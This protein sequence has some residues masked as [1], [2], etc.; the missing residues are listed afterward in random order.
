MPFVSRPGSLERGPDLSGV[1]E[2]R[3]AQWLAARQGDCLGG[4]VMSEITQLAVLMYRPRWAGFAVSGRVNSYEAIRRGPA[5]R[6]SGILWL[7][8]DGRYRAD[9]VDEDDNRTLHI[10]DGSSAWF[11]ENGEAYQLAATDAITPFAALLSPAWVLA[12]YRLEVAGKREYAGRVAIAITGH[13]R[14]TAVP[15]SD[16]A[17]A[18]F[19]ALVDAE[20]GILLRYDKLVHGVRAESAEFT[21]LE[22][23][24]GDS[25]DPGLFSRPDGVRVTAGGTARSPGTPD[26]LAPREDAGAGEPVS[27][28]VVSQLYLAGLR[29]R[30]FS[31]L[32]R[33]RADSAAIAATLRAATL[34]GT[35][36]RQL[37]EF[38]ADHVENADLT[39]RLQMIIPGRFRIEVVSGT[40]CGPTCSVCDGQQLWQVLPDRVYRM[41]AAPAPAGFAPLLDLAWLLDGYR[42]S[43]GGTV[44]AAGR[45]GQRITAQPVSENG[46]H[47]HGIL[48]RV[49]FPYD[50]IDIIIDSSLGVPLRMAWSWQDQELFTAE[51]ADLAESVDEAAFQF[52]P[53][54]GLPVRTVASHLTGITAKD[55]AGMAAA[56]VQAAADIAKRSR[57]P[58][59]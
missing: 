29:Q 38:A 58:R 35:V 48:S 22:V 30:R 44:A 42:L 57:R 23:T 20:L 37:A 28:A 14:D 52:D 4:D 59:S 2:A 18:Q 1:A 7:A 19:E 6:R 16:T 32:L 54:P 13:E 24:E 50:A 36:M 34:R 39:A 46:M 51:L 49:S 27:D 5:A 26:S 8:P 21:E 17:D 41:P 55:V 15:A 33:E 9:L 56:A 11:A 40:V 45:P 12:A 53:P 43:P 31:A 47:G 10:S 25:P 3:G